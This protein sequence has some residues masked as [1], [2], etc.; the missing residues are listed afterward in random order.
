MN[1]K[2]IY[3]VEEALRIVLSEC[4][5][6]PVEEIGLISALGQSLAVDIHS[7]IDLPPFNNS[8]VDGYAVR[9][10]DLSSASSHNTVS[11][12]VV[13]EQNAGS[14]DL[15]SLLPG[16]AARVMTGAPVPAGADCV[17]MQEDTTQNNKPDGSMTVTFAV[18]PAK[19]E[20]LRLAG[21]D[22]LTGEM[23]LTQGMPLGAAEISMAAAVGRSSVPCYR[24]PRV[25]I[26]TTGNEVR[27]PALV[28]QLK[29]GEIYNSNRF[30][31]LGLIEQSCSE[32][33]SSTHVV[34][35]FEETCKVFNEL[36]A[37]EVDVIVCA[38]GVS[39]GTKDFVKPALEKLGRMEFWRVAMKPGKPV[40]F[41]YVNT[42]PF[43]GLPGNPAS[44]LVS[45]ELF[46]RP[47]LLRVAGR[48][49]V[50]RQQVDSILVDPI[51][52][53]PG[54]RE[55]VRAFTR[56]DEPSSQFISTTTGAQGSGRMRSL[57]GYNSLIIVQEES[58]GIAIGSKVSAMLIT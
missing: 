34:D 14:A 35:D 18:P 12:P 27:D 29:Y 30:L 25:A 8:A 40:V 9:C 54:R 32:T 43:F 42:V 52:H 5:L 2:S 51:E 55:F 22:V 28:G 4:R 37:S 56:W 36:S 41:G 57:V 11:L 7:S 38:G 49:D 44:V 48:S 50:S 6:T 46:V 39:V 10:S 23:I 33:M 53:D 3:T 21:S 16:S 45:F 47:F 15:L 1:S 26:V 24:K 13:I 19:G 31:L 17:V 58:S 20:N